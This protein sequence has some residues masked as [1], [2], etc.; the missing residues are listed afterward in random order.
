MAND[1]ENQEEE[2]AEF[3]AKKNGSSL[4]EEEGLS[5]DDDDLFFDEADGEGS[6]DLDHSLFGGDLGAD[7]YL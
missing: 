3:P 2:V 4:G 6:G 7:D 5:L 1:D